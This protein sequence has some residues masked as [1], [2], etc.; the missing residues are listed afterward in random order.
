MTGHP[1]HP[2]IAASGID[3]TVKIFSPEGLGPNLHSR[4]ALKDEYQ[5]RSK[6]EVNQ[7]SQMGRRDILEA[8]AYNIRR[9]RIV[10]RGDHSDSEN[11]RPD[12]PEGCETM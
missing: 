6:N 11:N 8:L 2:L 4:Q 10:I 12:P 7:H 5:I 9:R 1:Y 3:H